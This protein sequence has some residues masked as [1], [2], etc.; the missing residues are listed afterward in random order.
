[1]KIPVYALALA[2]A[3]IIGPD[4]ADAARP[5]NPV[6]VNISRDTSVSNYNAPLGSQD[7]LTNVPAGITY[8]ATNGPIHGLHGNWN[9][10]GL[11]R[12]R[13]QQGNLGMS[14]NLWRQLVG[15]GSWNAHMNV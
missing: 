2:A 10:S 13:N 1:M 8:E 3:G 7:R 9:I 5:A 12:T 6:Y 4:V 15:T 11:V 14:S